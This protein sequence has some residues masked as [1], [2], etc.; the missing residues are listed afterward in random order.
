MATQLKGRVN[1]GKIDATMESE[2]KLA[3]ELKSFPTLKFF[4]GDTIE[5]KD[6]IE[7]RGARE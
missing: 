4:K 1:V 2:L 6:A 3:F 5:I 7:H